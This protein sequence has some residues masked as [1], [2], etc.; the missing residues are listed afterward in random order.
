MF[1]N[2]SFENPLK[3]KSYVTI[4]VKAKSLVTKRGE[5]NHD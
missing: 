5:M 4:I 2:L 3:A 1:C